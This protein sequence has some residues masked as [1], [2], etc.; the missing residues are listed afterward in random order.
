[1]FADSVLMDS[2]SEVVS[3]DWNGVYAD[4]VV[5]GDDEAWFTSAPDSCADYDGDGSVG[6]KEFVMFTSAYTAGDENPTPCIPSALTSRVTWTTTAFDSRKFFVSPGTQS[7]V[8]AIEVTVRDW[9]S[10]P[11]P[12]ALLEINFINCDDLCFETGH[13]SLAATTDLD[14]SVAF[15]PQIGG[16]DTCEVRVEV[17]GQIAWESGVHLDS[18]FEVVSTDWNGFEADGKVDQ[19]DS[20]WFANQARLHPDDR[21]P[22]SDYND[23]GKLDEQDATAFT[24]AFIE[25]DTNDSGGCGFIIGIEDG[26]PSAL[27]LS[28]SMPNPFRSQT[29]ILYTL[30]VPT[31]ADLQVFDVNGR[32]VRQLL[33]GLNQPA[34]AYV[35]EWNGTD[36][37]GQ[38]VAPGVY[39]Y[40][41]VTP[42]ESRSQKVIRIR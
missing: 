2:F 6:L 41:L 42:T 27:T 34:G 35:I 12:Q 25:G 30:S 18:F 21:D 15:D 29:A 4:G 39:F 40:R 16:C 1:V 19:Q 8:G 20:L 3:S 26:A 38:Q 37:R 28:P 10:R 22:C 9:G 23:D 17:F 11:I 31:Q 13:D 36:S 7:E 5:N 14:G 32:L 33:R 24:V